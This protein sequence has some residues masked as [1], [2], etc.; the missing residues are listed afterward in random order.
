MCD[1]GAADEWFAEPSHRRKITIILNVEIMLMSRTKSESL[2]AN[3]VRL[4]V[5]ATLKTCRG[6]AAIL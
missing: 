4:F 3:S 5:D 6:R 1:G 2:K